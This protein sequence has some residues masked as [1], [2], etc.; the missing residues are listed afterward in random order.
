MRSLISTCLGP[1]GTSVARARGRS[2]AP[3]FAKTLRREVGSAY[4]GAVRAGRLRA[5]AA[6][7]VAAVV[8]SAGCLAVFAASAAARVAAGACGAEGEPLPDSGTFHV[9]TW[10]CG[11]GGT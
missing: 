8:I 6:L 11:P 1:D 5:E 2:G 4:A 3:A 9:T 7:V 10:I